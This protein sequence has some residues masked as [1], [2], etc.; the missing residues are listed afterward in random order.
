MPLSSRTV[1]LFS[2]LR[3]RPYD[4]CTLLERIDTKVPFAWLPEKYNHVTTRPGQDA[5]ACMDGNHLALF[6][7][8][9]PS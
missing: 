7:L 2:R 4:N 5:W 9:V 8:E 1:A 6:T 3:M